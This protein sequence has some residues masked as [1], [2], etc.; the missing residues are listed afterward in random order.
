[1]Y[2]GYNIRHEREIDNG[3]RFCDLYFWNE[4]IG[5]CIYFKHDDTIDYFGDGL[6]PITKVEKEAAI[7]LYR[8]I[9]VDIILLEDL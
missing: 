2:T 9:L 7:A 6:G 4:C 5:W 1:M 3:R 8:D